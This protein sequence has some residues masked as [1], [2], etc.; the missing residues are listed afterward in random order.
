MNVFIHHRF[1]RFQRTV[2]KWGGE[3]GE[4]AESHQETTSPLE[5]GG[6]VG[7]TWTERA[8]SV[9]RPPS[10]LLSAFT[11]AGPSLCSASSILKNPCV[12]FSLSCSGPPCPSDTTASEWSP[13]SPLLATPAALTVGSP[14]RLGPT[15]PLGGQSPG[16]SSPR[17]PL[18]SPKL[19]RGVWWLRSWGHTSFRVKGL[20][21]PAARSC[22][23]RCV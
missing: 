10:I 4:W 21:V 15:A 5:Q 6:R 16:A 18:L 22:S 23:V 11:S 12:A 8:G 19:R 7:R 9:V 1:R 17:P 20:H 13:H 14:P 2:L 3:G